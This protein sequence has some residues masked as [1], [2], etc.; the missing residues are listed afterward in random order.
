MLLMMPGTGLPTNETNQS[1][2]K[3]SQ[4]STSSSMIREMGG[5]DNTLETNALLDGLSWGTPDSEQKPL[6]DSVMSC[7]PK[8]PKKTFM[9]KKFK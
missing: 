7:K 2:S 5:I 6:D 9:S 3:T 8:I 4:A 1:S